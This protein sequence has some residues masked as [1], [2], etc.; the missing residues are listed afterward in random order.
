MTKL[1]NCLPRPLF[2]TL[3]ALAMVL[4]LIFMQ[5]LRNAPQAA[6]TTLIVREV[7]IAKLTPPP[8]PPKT[9]IQS[10]VSSAPQLLLPQHATGTSLQVNPIEAE[11]PRVIEPSSD[12]GK[13]QDLLPDFVV[14]QSQALDEIATFGLEQLDQAPRLIN[15]I[16]ARLPSDIAAQGVTELQLMLHVIIHE[17]GKVELVGTPELQYPQLTVVASKIAKQAYFTAP[18]RHGEKV[19]AEFYWPVRIKV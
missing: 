7:N 2:N 12:F 19:K 15:R 10:S 3:V 14:G 16:N 11:L 1:L 5:G 4:L 17:T 8:P 13:P 18:M 9:Q 6:S